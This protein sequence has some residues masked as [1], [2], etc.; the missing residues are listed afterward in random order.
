M[1]S[2]E[3]TDKLVEDFLRETGCSACDNGGRPCPSPQACMHCEPDYGFPPPLLSWL[4]TVGC[5]VLA[6]AGFIAW[7]VVS[8]GA[9]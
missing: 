5:V 9:G 7:L 4:V 8:M 2:Y 3:Y 6:L 1:D